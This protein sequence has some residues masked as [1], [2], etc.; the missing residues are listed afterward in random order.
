MVD[1]DLLEVMPW[2]TFLN[3][4]DH[5]L[6]ATYEY[7]SAIACLSPTT[8]PTNVLLND[9]GDPQPGSQDRPAQARRKAKP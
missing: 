4:T 2:P 9:C 1:G 7:L 3:M 6:D 8:D 5:Q